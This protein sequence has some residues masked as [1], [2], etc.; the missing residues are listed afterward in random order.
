MK[1]ILNAITFVLFAW[2]K[3][4]AI[5]NWWR[6]SEKTLLILSGMGGALGGIIGMIATH[7][8]VRKKRFAVGIPLMIIIHIILIV[9]LMWKK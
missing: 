6:V 8:K 2:D 5:K 4:C 1:I 3:L 7:H 9:M